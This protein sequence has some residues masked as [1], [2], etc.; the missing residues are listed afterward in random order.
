M[1]ALIRA[2]LISF[3]FST[4]PEAGP[5]NLTTYWNK[6]DQTVL[7]KWS[8]IPR[9]LIRGYFTHYVVNYS[10]STNSTRRISRTNSI[11]LAELSLFTVYTIRVAGS[12]RIGAGVESVI[13]YRTRGLRK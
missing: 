10:S 4:V 7:V 3:L 6:T 12:T 5:A 8:H 13:S 11:V 1:L 9:P 2:N